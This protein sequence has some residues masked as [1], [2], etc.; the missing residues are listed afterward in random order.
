MLQRIA[1][2]LLLGICGASTVAAGESAHG[3]RGEY[4][5]DRS[6][7]KP[8]IERIDPKI[9]FSD[10][11]KKPPYTQDPKPDLWTDNLKQSWYVHFAVRWTGRLVAKHSETYT[12]YVHVDDGALLWVDDKLLVSAW[13]EQPL[14][15]HKGEIKLTAGAVVLM[16]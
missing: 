14:A 4:F 15:E 16:R 1:S 9:E 10:W 5:L 8:G 6:F 2:L 13:K 3:L 12:I 11:G 7:S